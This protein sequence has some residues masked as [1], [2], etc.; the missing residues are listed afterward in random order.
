MVC[1]TKILTK[2]WS[3]GSGEGNLRAD[4]KIWQEW[5]ESSLFLFMIK[6][7]FSP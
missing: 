2:V 3:V 7:G 5:Q 4:K 1:K 6:L